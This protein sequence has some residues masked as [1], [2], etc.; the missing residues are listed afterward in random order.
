MIER[1]G[2]GQ[3]EACLNC[4]TPLAGAYCS[5]CGQ[6]AGATSLSLRELVADA[7]DSLTNVDGKVAV[8]LRDLLR[9]PGRLTREYLL[10][11]R[12]RYMPPVRLY[13]VCSLAYFLA[14]A[15]DERIRPQEK[16]IRLV[17]TG[18]GRG[19]V[20]A[21]AVIAE[22]RA[23][24]R[25]EPDDSAF[26]RWLLAR[27]RAILER[28]VVDDRNVNQIVTENIPRVLFVLMPFF[29]LLLAL[30][31]RHR[32]ATLA[33]HLLFALHLHAFIFVAL[34]AGKLATLVLGDRILLWT[35]MLIPIWIGIYG[36][37]M[38]RG[39]YGGRWGVTVLR[40]GF[41]AAVYGTVVIATVAVIASLLILY[42]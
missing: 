18:A 21:E 22:I 25:P 8:T 12:A 26:E 32:H 2:K 40:A 29:A 39:V 4:E 19:N 20:S 13:L 38:I 15:L 28:A 37:A 24:T 42:R 9:Y 7:W 30:V 31:Y 1:Q 41:V 33:A 23:S 5:T 36:T 3:T 11:R 6:S 27:R 34:L 14:S 17:W 16:R 35:A 10:G